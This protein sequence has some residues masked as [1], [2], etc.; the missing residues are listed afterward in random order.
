MKDQ[1]REVFLEPGLLRQTTVESGGPHGW[2]PGRGGGS[3]GSTDRLQATC[4]KA[5][6]EQ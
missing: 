6:R 5:V 1:V 3:A 2:E 4:G